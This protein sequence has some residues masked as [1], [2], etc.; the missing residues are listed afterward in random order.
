MTVVR[1]LLCRGAISASA[2]LRRV[3]IKVWA[4]EDGSDSASMETARGRAREAA[5]DLATRARA[6]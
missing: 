4:D 2:A 3:L 1:L 6:D 5:N